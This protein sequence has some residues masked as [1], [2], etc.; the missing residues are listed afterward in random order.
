MQEAVRFENK[1]GYKLA[2]LIE[3]PDYGDIEGFIILV[4]GLTGDKNEHGLFA[5]AGTYFCRKNFSVFRFDITGCG[6][7]EGDFQY[8]GIADQKEDFLSA[9]KF[10]KAKERIG[11]E[12]IY[13]I[14]FSLGATVAL[15]AYQS[16]LGVKGLSLWNPVLFPE[17]DVYPKYQTAE[18]VK[19]LESRGYFL[20]NGLKVGRK[21]VSD[22]SG[23]SLVSVIRSVRSPT[24][25][26]Q[27]EEDRVVNPEST[28]IGAVLFNCLPK[29][30]SIPGADHFFRFPAGA[31]Y[32]VLSETSDFFE[33]IRT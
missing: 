22:L 21:I 31:F 20:K 17:R 2:G 3:R 26:V 15:L 1:K 5:K 32:R 7:S 23:C 30:I 24:S 8:V 29:F 28:E 14:G 6:E 4:H 19:E 18:I 16:I 33:S 9:I 25:L 13:V 10:V 27:G 11:N 12:D